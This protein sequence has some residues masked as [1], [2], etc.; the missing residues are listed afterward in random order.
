MIDEV[1]TSKTGTF[2]VLAQVPTDF[3]IIAMFEGVRAA[4][5]NPRADLFRH[6][7][8]VVGEARWS[9]VAFQYDQPVAFMPSARG[10]RET[11]CGF[12]MIVEYAG[13]ATIFR[14]RLDLPVPFRTRHLT[15]VAPERINQAIAHPD[16]VFQKLRLRHMTV[17][18][19]ALQS[20]TLQS[21]DLSNAVG[22]AASSR[23]IAQA[24]ALHSPDGH[25]SA[26]PS[27]GRIARQSDR[28]DHWALV[29]YAI[30]MIDAITAAAGASSAF[31]QGFAQPVDFSVLDATQPTAF[32]ADVASLSDAIYEHE[33]H[34]LVRCDGGDW[35]ALTQGETRAALDALALPLEIHGHDSSK[36]LRN[37]AGDDVGRLRVNKAHIALRRLNLVTCNGV[38]VE[39]SNQPLGEDPDRLSLCAYLE[40]QRLFIVLFDDIS[41]AYIDGGLY[42]DTGL[43]GGG[44][45]LLAHLQV[46]DALVPVVS[47]KGV[48]TPAHI[49][50]DADSTFGVVVGDIAAQDQILVCDDLG[51]EWA[52]FIGLDLASSPKR[53]TFYHAKHGDLSLGAGPFHISVSQAIKNLGRMALA[54]AD[55]PGKIR[56]WSNTYDNETVRTQIHRVVRQT[57]ATLIDDFRDARLAPDTI[58][59]AMI[60]TSSL[61]KRAVAEALD[62]IAQG[63]RPTPYFVQLYW[64]LMSFFSACAEVNTHGYVVCRP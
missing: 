58:R 2:Y 34:R 15:R 1:L 16:A 36:A 54:E 61:S 40:Q 30:E 21:N 35:R 48:F 14:S 55:I 4:H 20:K 23:F 60:V 9:A 42:R 37:R 22:P 27:T 31:L 3:E 41:L 45:Q 28:V 18:Q 13:Y 17:S 46:C 26:T 59:R 25:Y 57:Q 38:E 47:E 6:V 19:Q 56:T 29:G 49:A 62:N 11:V 44:A 32:A 50:F 10:I 39:R 63:Q 12:L 8:E 7:R 33:T 64:L 51:D 43:E 5:L 52:D 53:L 24:Y